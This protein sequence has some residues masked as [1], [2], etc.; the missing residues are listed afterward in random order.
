MLSVKMRIGDV[1]DVNG[2]VI[3]VKVAKMYSLSRLPKS[4]ACC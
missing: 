3:A 1:D 2:L 4:K